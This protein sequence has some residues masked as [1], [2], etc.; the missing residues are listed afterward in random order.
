MKQLY[1]QKPMPENEVIAF[2][3]AIPD[4]HLRHTPEVKKYKMITEFK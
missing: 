4:L 2:P 1:S 3:C